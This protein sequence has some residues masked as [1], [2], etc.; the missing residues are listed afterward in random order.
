MLHLMFWRLSPPVARVSEWVSEQKKEEIKKQKKII[1]ILLI[2]SRHGRGVARSVLPPEGFRVM[3]DIWVQLNIQSDFRV[4]A[5]CGLTTESFTT[6]ERGGRKRGVK[7]SLF[8]SFKKLFSHSSESDSKL[9]GCE[10]LANPC[11]DLWVFFPHMWPCCY[12]ECKKKASAN[13]GAWIWR[14][15]YIF[16]LIHLMA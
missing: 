16:S 4:I 5:A 3:T 14:W 10:A 2:D 15:C 1:S 13:D 7:I 6:G 8:I 9:Y 12:K 11:C